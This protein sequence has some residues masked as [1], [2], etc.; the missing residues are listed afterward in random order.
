[1]DQEEAIG[2]G[3]DAGDLADPRHDR[4]GSGDTLGGDLEHTLDLVHGER[5]GPPRRVDHQ[6]MVF[7]PR[8]AGREPQTAPEVDDGQ[9]RAVQA[10]DSQDDGRGAGQGHDGGH[11]EGSLHLRESERIAL[12]LEDE[13]D[14]EP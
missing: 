8:G 3:D 1:M 12:L 6:Q 9:G 13:D 14:Q 5:D 11:R 10:Q 4:G 2:Q 7:R